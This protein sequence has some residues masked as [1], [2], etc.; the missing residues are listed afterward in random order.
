MIPNRPGQSNLCALT[1]FYWA[2]SEPCL[3]GVPARCPTEDEQHAAALRRERRGLFGERP[4]RRSWY[5]DPHP[6]YS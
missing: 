3:H 4:P 5:D 1:A 2:R 6:R